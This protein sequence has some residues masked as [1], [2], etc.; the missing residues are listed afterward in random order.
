MPI[1]SRTATPLSAQARAPALSAA[2][3]TP[4]SAHPIRI[5]I[6]TVGKE[7]EIVLIDGGFQVLLVEEDV[8]AYLRDTDEE[9]ILVIGN[10]GPSGRPASVLSVRDGG[11]PDGTVFTEIFSR[12][13]SAVLNGYL[14]IPSMPRGVQV[15]QTGLE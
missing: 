12:R 2:A 4:S 13:A 3:R 14:P 8:L 15:W 9:Q 7:A 1:N 5:T 6:L 10:R 11:I